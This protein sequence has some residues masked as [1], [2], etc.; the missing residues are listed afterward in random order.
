MLKI[1]LRWLI[2]FGVFVAIAYLGVCLFLFL[3]QT[4][5]IFFPYR[6][7]IAATP[8]LFHLDYKEVWLPIKASSGKVE[9]MYC[10][11]IP[12]SEPDAKVLLYLHGNGSNI[13]AAVAYANLFNQLGFSVL[14]IDYRGYGRSEGGFP[15]EGRVY[16]D[17]SV[18]WD[19]LVKEKLIPPSQIFVFGHS[20]G[21]AIAINLALQHPDAAGLIVESAFT[22][23]RQM[24]DYEGKYWMFPVNL[25]L[26]QRFDSINKIKSLQVPILLIHGT[27]DSVVPYTMSQQLFAAAPELKQLVLVPGAGHNN[28]AE[29]AGSQYFQEVKKFV[30]Q[31]QAGHMAKGQT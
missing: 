19:Y 2:G 4:R 31:V 25:L 24:V 15:T 16:Q 23:M 22:S 7:A 28:V 18:A 10:W 1:V 9:Q 20:L 21:G 29:V 27:A 3:W 8:E 17:A 14:V 6:R 11:W 26:N 12:A 5:F 13:G 30:Q